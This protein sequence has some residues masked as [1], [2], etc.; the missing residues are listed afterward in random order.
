MINLG[1]L[2]RQIN[3][4]PHVLHYS[5]SQKKGNCNYHNIHKRLPEDCN[6]AHFPSC[7]HHCLFDCAHK[8][9]AK[10][11]TL[12]HCCIKIKTFSLNGPWSFVLVCPG[13]CFISLSPQRKILPTFNLRSSVWDIGACNSLAAECNHLNPSCLGSKYVENAKGPLENQC[14]V[15]LL[16]ATVGM[17]W[18]NMVE[19]V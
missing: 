7:L 2:G 14:S 8:F 15:Y 3:K 16:R 18:C 10:V 1:K 17:W 6:M 4:S 13:W 11:M 5:D 12:G 9:V 19:S